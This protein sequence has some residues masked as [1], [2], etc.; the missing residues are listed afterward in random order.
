MLGIS[1]LG[2]KSW[3]LA[4]FSGIFPISPRRVCYDPRQKCYDFCYDFPLGFTVIVTTLRPPGG[5][6]PPLLQIALTYP[7]PNQPIS[8]SNL[9]SEIHPKVLSSP[10][11]QSD[12]QK[13]NFL[14]KGR[15]TEI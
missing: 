13:L 15:R 1:N 2:K 4:V 12:L 8:P 9:N 10:N 5:I 11:L 14:S 6:T 3:F 7:D